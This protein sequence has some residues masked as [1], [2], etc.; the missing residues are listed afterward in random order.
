MNHQD[1]KA[2]LLMRQ[3]GFAHVNEAENLRAE[4]Q[5]RVDCPLK[6]ISKV[7]VE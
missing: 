2:H 7:I 4:L 6:E 1:P 5:E 3:L